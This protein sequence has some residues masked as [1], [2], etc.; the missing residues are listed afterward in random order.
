MSVEWGTGLFRSFILSIALFYVVSVLT[1]VAGVYLLQ[2]QF[3][4]T[5]IVTL[6]LIA[7][8]F[9]LL[10]GWMFSKIAIEPLLSHFSTLER[11]SKET[12]HELNIPISTIKTN[13]GMLQKGCADEKS[14]KRIGR[15]V[16]A[17][18]LLRERYD[19]LDY[20]IKQQMRKESIETVAL[21]Q[22]LQERID[23]LQELYPQHRLQAHLEPISLK[24]D[25][26]GFIKVV[27]N[28][29]DNAVKYSPQG[30]TVYIDLSKGRLKI[31][32]EGRGMDE[33]ELFKV[34]DRYYQSDESLPGYG[35]G[36]A[37]VKRY[38][39]RFK[40]GLG[41]DSAPGKGTTV[42][43]NLSEVANDAG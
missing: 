24:L 43:L 18:D 27:D 35:I 10:L 17:C 11:F 3:A 14:L 36:L 34:F 31:T 7:L 1:I 38:C 37:L 6:L 29:I 8:P 40:I 19:E 22:V 12:L 16:S 41:I 32:D 9:S 25:R 39:D 20:L 33:V 21:A 15:I 26:M 28:L 23:A 5:S 30:S 4:L 13:A 42:T 2:Q